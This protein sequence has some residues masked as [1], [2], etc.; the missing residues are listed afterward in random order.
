M[1]D[2]FSYLLKTL[3]CAAVGVEMPVPDFPVDWDRLYRLSVKQDVQALFEYAA[4]YRGDP[5][6]PPYFAILMKEK[7]RPRL[8]LSLTRKIRVCALLQEL[9]KA[10]IQAVVLKGFTL[11]SCYAAPD[12][13]ISQDADLYVGQEKEEDANRC[14]ANLG[15]SVE[16]RS[17]TSHHTLCQ[18]EDT[19]V[20][21]IHRLLYDGFVEE[22]WFHTTDSREYIAEPFIKKQDEDGTYRTLG[23]TDHMLFITLHMIKHFIEKGMSLRQMLDTA[24]LYFR[25][26]EHLDLERY[27]GIL[28]DLRYARI[29]QAIMG[30]AVSSVGLPVQWL[31][32]LPS[33]PDASEEEAVLM[34]IEIGGYLGHNDTTRRSADWHR[35]TLLRILS[36]PRKARALFALIK[37]G[38]KVHFPDASYWAKKYPFIKGRPWLVPF[39]WIR[40][41]MHRIRKNKRHENR[42]GHRCRSGKSRLYL[43]RA[44]GMI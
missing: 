13:R 18:R 30:S 3:A 24:L 21:E 17:S 31:Q 4:G 41:E 34:D 43:F 38:W 29:V 8:A 15:C 2:E 11:A 7:A 9:E 44:F 23:M 26:C 39:T 32:K 5:V 40:Y 12:F 35:Y 19:G 25:E 27:W 6:V 22:I 28:Q 20:I 10:G 14:L 1:S 33:R 37:W 16:I 36:H 42:G